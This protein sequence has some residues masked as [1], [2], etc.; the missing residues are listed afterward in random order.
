MDTIVINRKLLHYFKY[1]VSTKHF[2]VRVTKDP[3]KK[4]KV[5]IGQ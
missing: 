4:R 3:A 1:L 5:T 2:V